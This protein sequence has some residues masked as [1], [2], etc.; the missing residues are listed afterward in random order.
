[1][2]FAV[3]SLSNK[4]DSS[5]TNVKGS[6]KLRDIL[7]IQWISGLLLFTIPDL[8]DVH[9]EGAEILKVGFRLKG[10]FSSITQKGYTR[11]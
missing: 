9:S 10:I 11:I 1:M 3:G 2:E 4:S 8:V 7:K 6:E 5:N